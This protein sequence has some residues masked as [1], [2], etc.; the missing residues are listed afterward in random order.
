MSSPHPPRSAFITGAGSGINFSLA[1][2]LLS[3]G[4]SVMIADLSL[5]PEAQA[6]LTQYPSASAVSARALFHQTD[7]RSWTSLESA[8]SA[9]IS[10]FGHIDLVVPGAGVYEPIWSNFW[11]PPGS[12]ESKDAIDGD[13]YASLDINLTHPIRLTQ[14]AITHFLVTSA[15]RPQPADNEEAHGS[16]GTVLHVSSIAGQ[17]TPFPMPIYNA[18]KHGINGFVRSLAKLEQYR[19][20]RVVAVAPGV[21]K[22]PLWTDHPEKLRA[23]DEG[24]DAWVTAEEVA[25]VM[26]G[27]VEGDELTKGSSGDEG[28]ADK[29]Q[30]RGGAIIEISM[31]R[32][33]EVKPFMDEGPIGRVGNTVSGLGV[34]EEETRDL[35]DEKWGSIA[36]SG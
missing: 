14:L 21:V 34:L 32:I 33:R 12:S 18:T 27:M 35:L 13:R 26:A 20:I 17:A 9:A 15:S 4:T 23:M 36:G 19:G 16:I 6:L 24:K 1:S 7:V 30:V 31:G 11:R 5:R 2:L 28:E 25:E 10:A 22:T 3:R 29:I 8:F